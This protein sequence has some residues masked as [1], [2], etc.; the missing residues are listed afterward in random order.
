MA[1]MVH[2]V[3]EPMQCGRC[4]EIII[5]KNGNQRYCLPC[6]REITRLQNIESGRRRREARKSVERMAEFRI[7]PKSKI[8]T[9]AEVNAKAREL[10]MSYGK[11]VATFGG[12]K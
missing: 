1:R 10:H 9:I 7:D 2:T 11:Y 8:P 12:G 5:C 6:K 3:G 4:G